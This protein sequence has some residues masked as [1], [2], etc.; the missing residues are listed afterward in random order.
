MIRKMFVWG[1]IAVFAIVFYG[2]AGIPLKD[3][4]NDIKQGMSRNDVIN[5]L[6]G[7]PVYQGITENGKVQIW[8]YCKDNTDY[9]LT[10]E[11]GLLKSIFSYPFE[12]C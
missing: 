1:Y 3:R 6:N 5:A 11:K 7:F 9:T 8:G 4:M 2:C 10:F 12:C